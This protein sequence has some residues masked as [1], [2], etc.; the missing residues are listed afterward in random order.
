MTAV[1]AMPYGAR[2]ITGCGVE[3]RLWAPAAR[4]ASVV[5]QTPRGDEQELAASSTGGGW[6]HAVAPDATAQTLYRWRIDGTQNVPDPA[7]RQAPQGPHGWCR[8]TDPGAYAWRSNGWKGRP[9]ADIVLYELH[10]G[11]FTPE[12]TYA[13]AQT[14]LPRL[15]ALG[16][17]AIE[18]MPL[19]T[20]GGEFGWGYDGVLPFAPH[21]SYGTP[22]E[23]K[24]FVDAAHALG[25]AVFL[26]VVYNH[27][28]PDGNYLNAYA[29]AF[30]SPT[31]QSPW[32]QAL[33]FDQDDSG[34]VREFF[35]HN[36]LYW[37][38]E[39]RID[40]LRLDA[41]HAIVD[42]GE[43]HILQ[44]ISGRVR[45]LA[46]A[47]GRH[48]HLVLEN[49][50]NQPDW[51]AVPPAPAGR[52][53]AQWNDDFHHALH[54]ALTGESHTY[55]QRFSGDP[56][57][58][59]ATVLTR[60][61]AFARD[62]SGQPMRTH[63][64]LQS[65]VQFTGNHDQI[66]NRAFG[67]RLAALV[68]HEA[69]ELALLLALLTPATP[70]VF[71]GDEFGAETPF[72]YF[73]DWHG[74]LRDAVQ[75][76]RQREFS[77]AVGPGQTLPD[78]CSADTMQ[79]SR[80]DWVLAELPAARQRSDLVRRALECRTEWLVAHAHALCDTGHSSERVGDSGLRI[81]W[82]YSDGSHCWLDINLGGMPI[83]DVP[84]RPL[85]TTWFQHR[86]ADDSHDG[87]APWAPWSARWIA[88]R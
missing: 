62:R 67:E 66:G 40:G 16:F 45:A 27:F 46:Q 87:T 26:D 37:V 9:W 80:L 50:K 32:G 2:L 64:P 13:A 25:L 41:V 33:N 73:A 86:W 11:T 30:F 10:V 85:G 51:L 68:P 65:L 77:H 36:A 59:L 22:D 34:P 15:A 12:G 57:A 20:F 70:M 31:H 14:H 38:E 21:P 35:I 60:G 76:G 5:I 17:T 61:M 28:G 44:D 4:T 29:P 8:V 58:L 71:M 55:Y 53:D 74:E 49:E 54:V 69:A 47:Q 6:W 79:A 23:L 75:A 18:L 7:A 56:I 82:Q 24:Y 42:D 48:V 3:M 84:A 83:A 1:H 39:F 43:R 88:S 72:L 81:C 19:S 78:P 63:A 52:F